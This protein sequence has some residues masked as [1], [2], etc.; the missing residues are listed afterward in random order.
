MYKVKKNQKQPT[1]A[2]WKKKREWCLQAALM[3]TTAL[4]Q[5]RVLKIQ[6]CKA[7]NY[8]LKGMAAG[9]IFSL[10]LQHKNNFNFFLFL[11]FKTSAYYHKYRENSPSF[12]VSQLHQCYVHYKNV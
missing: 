8:I 1:D 12:Q 3:A 4:W 10:L 11:K 5:N 2:P 6:F 7:L 9:L